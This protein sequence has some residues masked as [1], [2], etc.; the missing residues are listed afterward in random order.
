MV[1]G[2]EVRTPDEGCELSHVGGSDPSGSGA[3]QVGDAASGIRAMSY[4]GR[5]DHATT[6]DVMGWPTSVTGAGAPPDGGIAMSRKPIG[7]PRLRWPAHSG[8]TAGALAGVIA[9]VGVLAAADPAGGGTTA[10]DHGAVVKPAASGSAEVVEDWNR[11]TFRTFSERAVPVPVQ[12]LQ[13]AFVGAAVADAVAAIERDYQPYVKQ[14]RAPRGASIEAATATAAHHVL[15]ALGPDPTGALRAD[16]EAWLGRVQNPVARVAGI[17][18][19]VA[20]AAALLAAR[21]GDGRNAPITL[22]TTPGPGVWD[23]P[24]TG[25]L[26]PWLGFVKPFAVP[27]QTW[28]R[29]SGPYSLASMAY[30]KDFVEVKQMGARTG[31]RRSPDETETALFW[32]ANPVLQ[33]NAALRERL[34]QRDATASEA[35]RAFGLLGISTADSLVTCWR[36]KYDVHNWR[37]DAAIRRA[38]T[39]GNP[40]T[41]KQ[42]DWEPLVP[43][44]P[45]P[46]Y[47]SGHACVTG[48]FTQTLSHLYGSRWLDV[49]VASSVT[50]T[51]RHYETAAELNR[52]TK[53]ARIWLGLH[54]RKAMDDGNRIGRTIADY[55]A[56]HVLLP[57]G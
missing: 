5:F 51:S 14:A 29:L 2:G 11:I 22:V 13:A 34:A 21:E 42:A 43:T 27:N 1:A 57:R 7:L 19:G 32:S 38:D 36:A 47:T 41:R 17:R 30:A 49:T 48:A 9:V 40:W 53:N 8:A 25:M 26:A 3:S 56:T 52:E 16:Y 15:L 18:V 23:P 10:L 6:L 54:F 44:P 55:A 4:G 50:G 12:G 35:A 20:A 31:S 24:P 33:Y 39:D 37:P 46:D 45:Y 28:V